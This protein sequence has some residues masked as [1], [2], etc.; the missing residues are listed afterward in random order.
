MLLHP[1]PNKVVSITSYNAIQTLNSIHIYTN[2]LNWTTLAYSS[3]QGKQMKEISLLLA[4]VNI[5]AFW[6]H[7]CVRASYLCCVSIISSSPSQAS[8][9][10]I[11]SDW[12][13]PPIEW[14]H[15]TIYYRSSFPFPFS[16]SLIGY[17][18]SIKDI[19][20]SHSDT[21]VGHP[22]H[23]KSENDSRAGRQAGWLIN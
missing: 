7:T 1:T 19:T 11:T 14:H 15:S 5:A 3:N 9:R 21:E 2:W 4:F 8:K 18:L 17:V 13:R 20:H 12:T 16:Q 23:S 6:H 10:A 22:F